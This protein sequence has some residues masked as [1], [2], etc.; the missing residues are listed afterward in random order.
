VNAVLL[1][2]SAATLNQNA[3][4]DNEKQSGNNPDNYGLIHFESPFLRTT[5]VT[6]PH[7]LAGYDS[8]C[9]RSG[10]ASDPNQ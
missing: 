7:V 6:V 1:D 9:R 3:Q 2:L 5:N 8:T 4:H 10:E